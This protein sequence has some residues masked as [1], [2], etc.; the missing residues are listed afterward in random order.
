MLA[1]VRVP[2]GRLEVGPRSSRFQV[3]TYDATSGFLTPAA[4]LCAPDAS[5]VGGHCRDRFVTKG[6]EL[7]AKV[8][9]TR[10]AELGQQRERLLE[11]RGDPGVGDV[12]RCANGPSENAAQVVAWERLR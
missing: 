8:L 10:E 2:A 6:V 7:A 1:Q 9:V 3:V 5:G 12:I 4:E 11:H